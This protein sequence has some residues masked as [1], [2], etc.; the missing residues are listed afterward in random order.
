MTRINKMKN[1]RKMFGLVAVLLFTASLTFAQSD[2]KADAVIKSSKEKFD[3]LQDISASFT[4]TLNNP[5]LKKPI[6][7]TGKVVF[8]DSKYLITFPDEEMYSNGKYIWIKLVGDEE[9][10]KTDYTDESI[11]PDKIFSLYEKDMKSRYDGDDGQNHKITLFANDKKNDIWKTEL[12]ISKSTKLVSS[13]VMHARNGSTYEYKMA[14]IK[15]NS[16]HP[17][18]MFELDEVKYEDDGWI[19]NDLT[20]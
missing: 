20:E 13:A 17:D 5:N 9:I 2:K 18:S 1:F 6:V 14:N 19:V 7:K 10:T 4:Y 3:K 15:T 11:S 16:G 8:K 12:S